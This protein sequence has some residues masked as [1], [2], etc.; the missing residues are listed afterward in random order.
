MTTALRCLLRN[1]AQ[2]CS[3]WMRGRCACAF[4]APKQARGALLW[5]SGTWTTLCT[6]SGSTMDVGWGCS[7]IQQDEG[8]GGTWP[9]SDVAAAPLGHGPRVGAE[10][11]AIPERRGQLPT[12][13]LPAPP[14][15]SFPS[16]LLPGCSH[17][18][19]ELA[20]SAGSQTSEREKGLTEAV[21]APRSACT[22]VTTQGIGLK[23]RP[24]C[25]NYKL[26][27]PNG[28]KTSKWPCATWGYVCVC[29][30]LLYLWANTCSADDACI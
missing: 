1:R 27:Y 13:L 26:R 19:S 17:S 22:C 20:W 4:P 5:A 10:A 3:S 30:L 14:T 25:K 8:Q 15:H 12:G 18:T 7:K 21:S 28:V 9:G 24:L 16:S 6:G 11:R 23:R 29:K 2:Y